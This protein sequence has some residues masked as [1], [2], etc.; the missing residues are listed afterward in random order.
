[1][2]TTETVLV[3]ILTSLLSILFLIYI[4]TAVAIYK[5]VKQVKKVV[6]KAEEVV[7]S[8]ESAAEVFKDTGGKLAF[9]KLVRNIIKMANNTSRGGKK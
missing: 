5:L 2:T 8:V 4:V 7:D 6:I 3:I 1:M 9:F